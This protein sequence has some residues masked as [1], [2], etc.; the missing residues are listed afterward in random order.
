MK[1]RIIAST[2]GLL[3]SS[4]AIAA[5]T[6][7]QTD[8][9]IVTATRLE[10]KDTE[11]TY[12]SEIHTSKMIEASGATSLYDYLSQH[13]SV[14]TLPNFGNKVTPNIDM[15][16]YGSA[17]GYQNIVVTV[18]GQRLNNIDQT[19]Q[20]IGAIPLGNIDRIEITKGSGSVINGDGAMAGSIQ[21][22][23]KVKTGVSAAVSLGSYGARNGYISAGISEQY[24]DLSASASDDS[25]DGFSKKDTTG[26]RD[27]YSS[28]A[29]N[30]KLALK[31][32][33]DLRFNIEGTSSRTDARYNNALTKDQFKNDPRQNGGGVYNHQGID[34]DMW[35]F[36]FEY[37][38]TSELK[39]SANHI[40]EDKTSEF[41]APFPFRA[42]Y[43]YYSNDIAL[44]YDSQAFSA[45]VG[46]QTFDGERVGSADKTTK[47]N[48]ALFLQT[49]Y[50]WNALTV[51]G[52]AR[53]EK[54]SYDYKPNGAT[55]LDDDE[56]LNA[57]D[58]GANYRINNEVSLFANYNRA[59]QAPDID[60]FFTWMGTFNDFIVPA[61]AKTL[62]IGINHVIDRNRLKITAFRSNLTDEIYFN[63]GTGA[64]T[65][66]DKSHKYGLE[67]QDYF[68]I[69][70]K[71]N[72]GLI[73]TYTR[74]IIDKEADGAGTFNGKDVPGVS[75]HSVVANLGYNFW[76]NANVNLSHV[77]RSNSYAADDFANN[78]TQK[79]NSYESTNLALN[80]RYK[81]L[82]WFTAIN[83]I[84]EHKNS[85]QVRDDAIYPV[86][87]VRTWRVG[88]KADF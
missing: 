13:T 63:A 81:N 18:D 41:F 31:P 52:G 68:K 22:Y 47:D 76:E 30:I 84:F 11:T 50:R 49:E 15:R 26:K 9:I 86:D 67:V 24:F 56:K 74:A 14:V 36:G 10:R 54:V 8:D 20:L 25:H 34:S 23:T 57:W 35:R 80:Y 17:S 59:Y 6:S 61:K 12:A 33:D 75:T 77:W 39:I 7:I 73:Y 51:S 19:G 28:T 45:V 1:K 88:M 4:G 29:Q 60:R 48:A 58:I 83:N 27:G 53:R 55:N 87:F 64:N 62:N 66:L 79:Q 42:D 5:D 65:N 40:R 82:Q 16:G 38:L 3:I 32:T 43:N 85:I 70:D 78:F 44:S 69:T 71:L 21:I 2:I 72:T 37:K 46:M